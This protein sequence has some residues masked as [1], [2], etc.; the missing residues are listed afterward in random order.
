M[1]AATELVS[2]ELPKAEVFDFLA[3]PANLPAWFG[4]AG[5]RDEGARD[6]VRIESDSA[7]GVVDVWVRPGGDAAW[8]VLPVRV[9][10][11]TPLSSVVL[12]TCF[13]AP[14]VSEARFAWQ[15]GLLRRQLQGLPEAIESQLVRA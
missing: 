14:E 3:N 13:A 5:V 1:R 4:E 2:I 11:L 15:V 6:V 10:N 7:T 8:G 9:M 12:V